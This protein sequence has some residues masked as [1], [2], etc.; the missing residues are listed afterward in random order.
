MTRR[1]A[2]LI[3]VLLMGVV[4]VFHLSL[5]LGAPFG[6]VTMG[7]RWPGVLPVRGRV[8][9]AVSIV[10]LLLLARIVAVAGALAPPR[11]PAASLW[12]VALFLAV[13]VVLHI[14]TPSGVERAIWLPQIPVQGA[15][16]IRLLR[17]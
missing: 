13:A 4:V 15:C 17:A 5:I 2:A 8:A 6:G 11:L 9:S 12:A 1:F 10:V 7:G 16:V 14:I 3:C